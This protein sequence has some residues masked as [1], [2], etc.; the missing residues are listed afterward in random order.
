MGGGQHHS[1]QQ[2]EGAQARARNPG[3]GGWGCGGRARDV[4]AKGDRVAAVQ[5]DHPQEQYLAII[6]ALGVVAGEGGWLARG[7][8]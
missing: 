2:G 4:M 8:G 5:M 7:G 3:G 6:L 1:D